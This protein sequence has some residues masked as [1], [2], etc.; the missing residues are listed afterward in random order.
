MLPGTRLR[1]ARRGSG[2]D[3]AGGR[4]DPDL[5]PRR[6]LAVG[7]S[8]PGLL[9]LAVTLGLVAA[10]ILASVLAPAEPTRQLL[11]ERLTPPLWY[12]GGSL[13]Y[14]LGTD[15]LGRDLLSRIL[16]G[17]RLS[18][19]IAAGAVSLAGLAGTLLG[20]LAGHRGGL[21]DSVI[22][23]L[24]DV[25]MAVPFLVLAVAIVAALGTGLGKLILVL[26]LTTWVSY[27]RL[28]RAEALRL[29]SA[30]FVVAARALGAS[31]ARILRRHV[32]PN[33]LGPIVILATQQVAAVILFEAALSFLGLGP[34]PP[35]ITWGG[36]VAD[37]RALLAVAWWVPTL[38]GL[39]I[40]LAALGV[41]LLGDWLR[42]TLYG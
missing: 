42:D 25:Q 38:P 14:P 36:M 41:N 8:G 33:L 39:A 30:E 6:R 1:L 21:A 19:V 12:P 22:M 28:A 7:R 16:F 37:G 18:L 3:Q 20:T 29:R 34:Q 17:A 24:V 5:R 32:I 35:A 10:A 15:H 23:R 26:A 40:F 11:G 4:S 2:A 27:A 9:G 13:S 31:E